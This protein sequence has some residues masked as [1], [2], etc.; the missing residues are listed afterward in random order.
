MKSEAVERGA[1]EVAAGLLV[2]HAEQGGEI[3]FTYPNPQDD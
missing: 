1:G 3:I 2:Q